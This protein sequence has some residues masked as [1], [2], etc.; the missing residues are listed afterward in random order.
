MEPY[1]PSGQGDIMRTVAQIPPRDPRGGTHLPAI[2]PSAARPSTLTAPRI[3]GC[4]A[5]EWSV[6]P[7]RRPS[8][9]LQVT[10]G[11]AIV[12]LRLSYGPVCIQPGGRS[13]RSR[14]AF[15]RFSLLVQRGRRTRWH[16]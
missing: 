3:A 6:P 8:V 2:Y 1:I 14:P 10:R 15:R 11:S 13:P 4:C 5:N 16:H 12:G 7:P 9:G